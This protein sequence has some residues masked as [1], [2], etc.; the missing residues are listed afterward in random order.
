MKNG[1]DEQLLLPLT[2]SIPTR[3]AVI[4]AIQPIGYTQQLIVAKYLHQILKVSQNE[5][6]F[7]FKTT[8]RAIIPETD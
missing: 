5:G 2:T 7:I 4:G 6:A 1:A 8:L 3:N